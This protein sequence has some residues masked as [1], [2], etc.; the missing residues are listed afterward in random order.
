MFSSTKDNLLGHAILD[1]FVHHKENQL[2][3][4]RHIEKVIYCGDFVS[5][6]T[7]ESKDGVKKFFDVSTKKGMIDGLNFTVFK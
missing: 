7:I 1:L 5:S 6:I 2:K 4:L 3:I